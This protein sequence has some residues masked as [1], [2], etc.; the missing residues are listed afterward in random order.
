LDLDDFD[1]GEELDSKHVRQE[2]KVSSVGFQDIPRQAHDYILRMT[3]DRKSAKLFIAE[4]DEMIAQ[5]ASNMGLEDLRVKIFKEA[6]FGHLDLWNAD[7][8]L[9]ENEAVQVLFEGNDEEHGD[10]CRKL[11]FEVRTL[12]GRKRESLLLIRYYKFDPNDAAKIMDLAVEVTQSEVRQAEQGLAEMLSGRLELSEALDLLPLHPLPV[13]TEY[14]AVAL[15]E[16]IANVASSR[17]SKG[18]KKRTLLFALTLFFI[19]GCVIYF[20]SV[21]SLSLQ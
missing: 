16:I 2:K 18:G 13:T 21:R 7:T 19:I 5:Y 20:I 3:G 9:L 15:S 8:N 14:S 1:D 10:L 11:D 4:A 17:D 6:R 12:P